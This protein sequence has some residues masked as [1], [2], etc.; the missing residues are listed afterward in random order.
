MKKNEKEKEGLRNGT[1][2]K[3]PVCKTVESK[4][5]WNYYPDT[6]NWQCIH[7][8]VSHIDPDAVKIIKLYSLVDQ[9]QDSQKVVE[10]MEKIAKER[11][12]RFTT[13]MADWLY[14]ELK[15]RETK[16]KEICIDDQ[17]F[18]NWPFVIEK[19]ILKCYGS[20]R[21]MTVIDVETNIEYALNGIAKNYMEKGHD[22][23]L[24]DSIWRDDIEN[25][26]KISLS[27]VIAYVESLYEQN[28]TNND[29]E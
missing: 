20:T 17:I 29:E 15:K 2:K 7:C 25:G 4:I 5:N 1:H 24:I 26:Y 14:T 13:K 10:D 8:G 23:E 21:A 22:F 12:I 9:C 16:E 28:F 18:K 11:N 19:V 3:C 27:P 6:N